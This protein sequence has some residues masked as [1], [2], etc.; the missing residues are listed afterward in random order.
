MSN[1]RI[2]RSVRLRETPA[3]IEV[4]AN[5]GCDGQN[6]A[7]CFTKEFN[8]AGRQ[9]EMAEDLG[10]HSLG[11]CDGTCTDDDKGAFAHP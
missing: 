8:N 7:V 10:V 11:K 4:F 9:V 3:R 2:Y 5:L 1:Y 6:H